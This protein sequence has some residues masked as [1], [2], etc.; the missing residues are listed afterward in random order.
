MGW[1]LYD[2]T[3]TTST[4]DEESNDHS[5]KHSHNVQKIG[6]EALSQNDTNSLIPVHPFWRPNCEWNHVRMLIPFVFG[7]HEP[8]RDLERRVGSIARSALPVLIEGAT[9]TGK[10]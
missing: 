6:S 4:S 10:D 8:M 7:S 3:Y 1:L 5:E 9:G 2:P